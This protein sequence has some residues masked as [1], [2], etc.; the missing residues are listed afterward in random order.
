MKGLKQMVMSG[1]SRFGPVRHISASLRKGKDYVP[2]GVLLVYIE[3]QSKPAYKVF[4]TV[5]FG[6][7]TDA[8]SSL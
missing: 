5:K 4:R 1:E 7:K 6:K 2:N 3:I 8:E